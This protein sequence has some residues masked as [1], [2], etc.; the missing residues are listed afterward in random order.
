MI[1]INN[2]TDDYD[3]Y[4]KK[5]FIFSHFLSNSLFTKQQQWWSLQQWQ[6]EET[7]EV[8]FFRQ[9]PRRPY[10][11]PLTTGSSPGLWSARCVRTLPPYQ[12]TII[13]P[14][15]APFSDKRCIVFFTG[16]AAGRAIFIAILIIA[17]AYQQNQ[18]ESWYMIISFSKELKMGG[19]ERKKKKEEKNG[20]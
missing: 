6:E 13:P 15:D 5:S 1:R 12:M 8:D 20:K 18:T 10:V 11:P 19:G 4:E 9:K 14:F 16:A 3:D 7:R 2:N 17:I